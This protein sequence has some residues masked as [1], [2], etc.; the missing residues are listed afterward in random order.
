MENKMETKDMYESLILAVIPFENDDVI[1]ES[2]QTPDL[3]TG[4]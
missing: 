4:A 3:F 1:S 2:N